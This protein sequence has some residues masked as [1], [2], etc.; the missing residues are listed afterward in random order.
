MLLRSWVLYHGQGRVCHT[1]VWG[2]VWQ[3]SC[4]LLGCV[5]ADVWGVVGVV[6]DWVWLLVAH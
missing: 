5:V 2:W 3:G 4:V 6:P 1:A